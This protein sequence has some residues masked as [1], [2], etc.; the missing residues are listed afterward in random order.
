M[1]NKRAFRAVRPLRAALF[2]DTRVLRHFSEPTKQTPPRAGP[3]ANDGLWVI[4]PQCRFVGWNEVPPGGD[5]GGG[6]GRASAG[7]GHGNSLYLPLKRAVALK[8][9]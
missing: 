8:R 7:G 9:L 3:S 2:G 4:T 5:V 1:K 6:G